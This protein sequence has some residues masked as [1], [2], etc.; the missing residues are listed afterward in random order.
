M[1]TLLEPNTRSFD[2]GEPLEAQI[3]LLN[4]TSSWVKRGGNWSSDGYLKVR[5]CFKGS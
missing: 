5:R 2:A 1:L 3:W 4:K